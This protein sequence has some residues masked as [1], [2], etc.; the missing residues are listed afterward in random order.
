MK[1]ENIVLEGGKAGGR[2]FLVDFGDVQAAALDQDFGSTIIGKKLVLQAVLHP[3]LACF[4]LFQ[5]QIKLL[6]Q[7]PHCSL[8]QHPNHTLLYSVHSVALRVGFHESQSLAD[9]QTPL[10]NTAQTSFSSVICTQNHLQN[11]HMFAKLSQPA[12]SFAWQLLHLSL[13][14]LPYLTTRI[15]SHLAGTWQERLA[16]TPVNHHHHYHFHCSCYYCCT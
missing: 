2:V 13:F 5:Q 7:N 10:L 16:E 12:N 1:P 4:S 3:M 6:T 14:G 8:Q 15:E 11:M 9:H